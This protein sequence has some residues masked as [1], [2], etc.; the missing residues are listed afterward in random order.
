M[1]AFN[2]IIV[3]TLIAHYFVLI[4]CNEVQQ[5]N[6]NECSKHEFKNK[7][8]VMENVVPDLTELFSPIDHKSNDDLIDLLAV[9]KSIKEENMVVVQGKK[10]SIHQ[11]YI[12]KPITISN[13]GHDVITKILFKILTE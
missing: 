8:I 2:T 1:F 10:I 4:R 11:T 7:D 12:L 9:W 13:W 6:A 5:H 3:T